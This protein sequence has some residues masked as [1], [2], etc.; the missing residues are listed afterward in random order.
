MYKDAKFLP[1]GFKEAYDNLT[2]VALEEKGIPPP[3]ARSLDEIEKGSTIL[4][5]NH[6]R[7]AEVLQ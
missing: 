4:A 7:F 3:K 5:L 6:V 2:T 1:P